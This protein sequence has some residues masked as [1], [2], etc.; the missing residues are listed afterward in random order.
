MPQVGANDRSRV[1]GRR[2]FVQSR[3][4]AGGSESARPAPAAG[5]GLDALVGEFA[6]RIVAAVAEQIAPLLERPASPRL[7]DRRGLAQALDVGVDTVDKLR[8][9]GLPTVMVVESPRFELDVVIEWLRG[10]A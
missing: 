9:E 8:R 7:L 3:N 1:R 5:A 2:E 10:R 6:E 4:G